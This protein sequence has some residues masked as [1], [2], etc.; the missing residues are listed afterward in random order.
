MGYMSDLAAVLKNKFV[1]RSEIKEKYDED[2]WYAWNGIE[3]TPTVVEYINYQW[4][5]T[6]TICDASVLT[7]GESNWT[8]NLVNS[9]SN[10]VIY[11]RSYVYYNDEDWA[12]LA[13]SSPS[14]FKATNRV[15]AKG[16]F[17]RFNWDWTGTTL[18]TVNSIT[19]NCKFEIIVGANTSHKTGYISVYDTWSYYYRSFL[20]VDNIKRGIRA[21]NL[22][23]AGISANI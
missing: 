5:P 21:Y 9:S 7:S 22:W 11:S 19:S 4:L 13:A 10:T 20:G 23:Q 1:L 16:H 8:I 12:A 2:S 15:E 17:I 14:V 3:L 18:E 6:K